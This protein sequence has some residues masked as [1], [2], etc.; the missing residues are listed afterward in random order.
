MLLAMSR[1]TGLR[2]SIGQLCSR[3]SVE[4]N[5]IEI[6]RLARAAQ[7]E[8]SKMLFLPENACFMGVPGTSMSLEVAE[9]LDDDSGAA[10]TIIPRLGEICQRYKLWLSVGGFQ[11]KVS[12]EE[13]VGKIHNTHIVID[14]GGRIVSR[15]RKI[16]LFDYKHLK[17]SLLTV[18][19]TTTEVC[20]TPFGLNLGLSVCFDLRFP[21]LYQ[22]LREQGANVMLIP[23]AFTVDTGR[24][25][26]ETLIRA[27]AIETQSWVIAAAQSGRHNEKRESYGHGMV[28]DPW[29]KVVVCLKGDQASVETFE[30]DI[31]LVDEVRRRFVIK[32]R[33]SM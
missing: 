29:G 25:H 24:A 27:R 8:A 33:L 1:T 11:E 19:G 32:Q 17:E 28:V 16:H 31:G 7:S 10:G 18:P 9:S 13:G 21:S 2:V 23:A 6:D 30:L 3:A 12:G 14:D 15:Y 26:W 20:E 4:Q 22:R 5:L